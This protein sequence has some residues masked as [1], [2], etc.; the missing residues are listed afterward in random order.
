VKL[1][2]IITAVVIVLLMLPASLFAGNGGKN[3]RGVHVRDF[4]G[5][6]LGVLVDSG[7]EEWGREYVTIFIP[8]I[9]KLAQ[10]DI[11]STGEMR[12]YSWIQFDDYGCFGNAYVIGSTPRHNGIYRVGSS[13]TARYFYIDGLLEEDV[14]LYSYLRP[15]TGNCYNY[16]IPQTITYCREA[17]E[18]DTNE[19][20]FYLPITLPVSYD[21]K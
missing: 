6:Y 20:P 4:N 1:L 15:D 12:A 10:I 3:T 5:Q 13:D 14:I 16:M 18:I 7:E 19:I 2:K 17:T 8:S 9:M 21:T 11:Q